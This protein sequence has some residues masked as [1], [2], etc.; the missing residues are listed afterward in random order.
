MTKHLRLIMLTLLAMICMGGY[1]AVGDTYKLVTSVADLHDGDVIVIANSKSKYAMGEQGTSNRK[2]VQVNIA[3]NIF[4]Y[5]EGVAELTLKASNNEWL[6]LSA[7]GYL[8]ASSGTGKKPSNKLTSTKDELATT[9][10]T[11]C[12]ALN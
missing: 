1:S 2:A 4:S 10:A 8:C 11:I 9:K 5:V 7:D 3:N 6:F 12:I